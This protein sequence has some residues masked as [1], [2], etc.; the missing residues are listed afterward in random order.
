MTQGVRG[1]NLG[2]DDFV[3][4]ALPIRHKEDSLAVFSKT[5]LGKKITSEELTVQ[6]RGGRGVICYKP[7]AESG[8]IVAACLVSDEDNIL[9]VG[10][11]SSICISAKEIPSL[12]R[13]S[14]GNIILKGNIVKSVSKV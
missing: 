12:G 9:V 6:K 3:V 13:T 1:I 2:K 8:P 7:N 10:N 5:G 4:T 14:M 11:K